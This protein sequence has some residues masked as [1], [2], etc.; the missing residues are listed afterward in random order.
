MNSKDIER[1][2]L[3]TA[4][5]ANLFMG[6]AGIGAA[7]LSNASALM[8]DGL[9]SGVNFLA[10]IFA[11]KVAERVESKPDAL[12]PFGY[13]IDEAVFVMFRSLVLTGIVILAALS[14]CAKIYAFSV[15]EVIP[16]IKLNWIV[17]YMVL[18]VTIC[19]SL[20]VWHQANLRKTSP[21]SELLK[22]ERTGA[23]IDG[24]MSLAAGAAFLGISFL[25]GT[26]LAFLVPI[27]DA[28]VVLALAAYIAPHPIR[29]FSQA[30]RE[31]LGESVDAASSSEFRTAI[32]HAFAEEPFTVLEVPVTKTGRSLFA[33]AYLRPERAM[34]AAALD[35][36]RDR[37]LKAFAGVHPDSKVRMEVLFTARYPYLR[38]A[39]EPENR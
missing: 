20:A 27:S 28:I 31:V 21:P 32:E 39:E 29:M 7:L 2:S 22:T 1:R 8:L 9:F 12:R 5:W 36:A 33:V 3:T 34:D 14:A 17:V 26:F 15:G 37:A 35:A 6:C 23:L 18:M 30:L 38:I 11:A 13:E 25:K 10:A 19:F 16:E 24:A 4:K